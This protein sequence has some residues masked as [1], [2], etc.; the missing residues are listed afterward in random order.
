MCLSRNFPDVFLFSAWQH[1]SPTLLYSPS[2]FLASDSTSCH[3][4][5]LSTNRGDWPAPGLFCPLACCPSF[6]FVYALG[7]CDLSS[8]DTQ[9][10]V[11]ICFVCYILQRWSPFRPPVTGAQ[12]SELPHDV[13]QGGRESASQHALFPVYRRSSLWSLEWTVVQQTP[14][15]AVFWALLYVHVEMTAKVASSQISTQRADGRCSALG[16]PRT[17]RSLNLGIAKGRSKS[18]FL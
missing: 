8:P 3:L 16:L 13:G 10:P 18:V 17:L 1:F 7:G 6:S 14:F 15:L 2:L 5:Y 12:R 4:H 9:P 11:R